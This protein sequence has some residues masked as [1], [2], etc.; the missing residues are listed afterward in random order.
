[1][2]KMKTDSKQDVRGNIHITPNF[3]TFDHS[4]EE[5]LFF[6]QS[7]CKKINVNKGGITVDFDDVV[8]KKGKRL[9]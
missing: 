9:K 2:T 3:I 7:D 8:V 6:S 5:S 4:N 1:M